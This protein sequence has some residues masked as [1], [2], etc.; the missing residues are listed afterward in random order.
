MIFPPLEDARFFPRSRSASPELSAGK[1]NV[2]AIMASIRVRSFRAISFMAAQIRSPGRRNFSSSRVA[3]LFRWEQVSLDFR[4]S[5]RKSLP[6]IPS[7]DWRE[8]RPECR[9]DVPPEFLSPPCRR[10]AE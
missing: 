1:A 8:D 5:L 6:E 9:D 3:R 10:G 7:P 2:I 4:Q